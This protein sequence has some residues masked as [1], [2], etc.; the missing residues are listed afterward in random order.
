[1]QHSANIKLFLY[2]VTECTAAVI[3]PITATN[4]TADELTDFFHAQQ[5]ENKPK[6]SEI[7]ANPPKLDHTA[8]KKGPYVIPSD[9]LTAYKDDEYWVIDEATKQAAL[10]LKQT[11]NNTYIR[12]YCNNLFYILYYFCQSNLLC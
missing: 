5:E 9:L 7:L 11:L 12:I 8:T 4:L 10:N 6:G 3:A 2:Q 1:M